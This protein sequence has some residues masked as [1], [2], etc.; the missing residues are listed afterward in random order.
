[1]TV[2]TT[3][4]Q[5]R[6]THDE[7]RDRRWRVVGLLL[8]TLA[9]ATAAL[10]VTTGTRPATYGDLLSDV[11]SS[12]V[13]EVQVS[14]PETPEDGDTVELRWSV[15]GGVLDQYAVV[16]VAGSRAYNAW[17]EPVFVT[18]EDPRQTLRD[19][20]PFVRVTDGPRTTDHATMF[21]GWGVP[22]QVAIVGMASWLAVLLLIVGGPEPW[23]ATRW[24]WGW[25][26]LLTG[27]LGSVAYLLLGG[28]TGFRRPQHGHRRLTGGWAFLLAWL[29]FA[30]WRETNGR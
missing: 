17:D 29:L 7:W 16:E 24:A 26:W 10:M 8:A 27:P 21:M 6:S 3:P 1:M 22:W 9:L 12:K 15:L 11:A 20:N 19:I 18:A 13:D 4:Q 30:G 2:T 28:P 5:A 23:R 14:G 25:A